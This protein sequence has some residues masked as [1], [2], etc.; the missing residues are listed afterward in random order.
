MRDHESGGFRKLA[1]NKWI[2][3]KTCDYFLDY[4]SSLAIN[5]NTF[6]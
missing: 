5:S 1:V 3:R 6:Y 4:F 2:C